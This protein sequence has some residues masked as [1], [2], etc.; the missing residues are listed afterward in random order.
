MAFSA[1]EALLSPVLVYRSR[2][3]MENSEV[4]LGGVCVTEDS[5]PQPHM[6]MLASNI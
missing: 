2:S 5:G 6:L 3:E 1:S 4:L